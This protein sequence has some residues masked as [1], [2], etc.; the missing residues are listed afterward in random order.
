MFCML[1]ADAGS[2]KPPEAGCAAREEK[3]FPG[4]SSVNP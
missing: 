1:Q 2:I 4:E 3:R